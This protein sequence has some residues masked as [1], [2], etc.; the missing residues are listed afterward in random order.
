MLYT[1]CTGKLK[2]V[3]QALDS[4]GPEFTDYV[5]REVKKSES[6]AIQ[7]KETFKR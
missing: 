3:I 7:M 2:H 1:Y 4:C 6:G 5:R